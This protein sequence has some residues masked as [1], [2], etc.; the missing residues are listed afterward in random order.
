MLDLINTAA[1]MVGWFVFV[2]V[3]LA[4]LVLMGAAAMGYVKMNSD[5][6]RNAGYQA[7]WRAGL[8]HVGGEIARWFNDTEIY[9]LLADIGAGLDAEQVR[10][11]WAARKDKSQL[12]YEVHV[13]TDPVPESL[14]NVFLG[15][16]ERHGFRIA[17][18]LMEKPGEGLVSYD[19]DAFCTA[20]SR[21]YSEAE[22]RMVALM[23]DLDKAGIV[24]RRYK[25]EDTLLDSR[26]E[27]KFGVKLRD[28]KAGKAPL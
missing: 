8:A 4:A 25:I 12:Y 28:P 11:N 5:A 22:N 27:N 2:L 7:G 23:L 1:T 17:S 14:R 21:Y 13:T 19:G 3:A 20:R 15:I 26:V 6:C 24:L 18:L 10:K 16:C 9:N